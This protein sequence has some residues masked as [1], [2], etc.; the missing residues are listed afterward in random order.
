MPNPKS[1]SLE[2]KITQTDG[3]AYWSTLDIFLRVDGEDFTSHLI[4]GRQIRLDAM[5]EQIQNV[6]D[7]E[8]RRICTK[9]S[10]QMR[11]QRKLAKGNN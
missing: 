11:E 10:S 9:L 6:V 2:V 5:Y 8:L 3:E 7:N 4:A 1:Y